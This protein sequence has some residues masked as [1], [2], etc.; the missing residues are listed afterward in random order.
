MQGLGLK[1]AQD[2]FLS[3]VWDTK[4]SPFNVG[5]LGCSDNHLRKRPALQQGIWG[6]YSRPWLYSLDWFLPAQLPEELFPCR[7]WLRWHFGQLG[8]NMPNLLRAGMIR[9][10]QSLVLGFFSAKSQ[11][12]YEITLFLEHICTAMLFMVDSS[13]REVVDLMTEVK[14][15][16]RNKRNYQVRLLK[17]E[18]LFSFR[19]CWL[20]NWKVSFCVG[21]FFLNGP[22]SHLHICFFYFIAYARTIS[23][24]FFSSFGSAVLWRKPRKCLLH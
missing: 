18:L 5:L 8:L 9:L 2:A 12:Q 14:A 3:S 15:L 22:Q 20:W 4:G 24:I 19:N 13:S 1:T 17:E 16:Y 23:I 21:I 7:T 10:Q 6:I 11:S